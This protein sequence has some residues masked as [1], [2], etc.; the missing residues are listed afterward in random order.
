MANT[1]TK[2]TL[3][4]GPRNL[5]QLINID[6]D[7]SGNETNT[8]LVDRSTFVPTDGTELVVEKIEGLLSGFTAVLSFD[9]TTDLP[10]VMFPNGDWFCHDWTAIGGISSNKAGAGANGDIL[11]TTTGLETDATDAATFI[12]HMRKA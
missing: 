5:V 7:A 12:L 10:F 9:A 11:L 8:V 1:I 4:D 3:I 2:T 6:G